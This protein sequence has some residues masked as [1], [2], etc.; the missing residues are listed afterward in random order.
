M[1]GSGGGLVGGGWGHCGVAGGGFGVLIKCGSADTVDPRRHW[2]SSYLMVHVIAA[3]GHD[4]LGPEFFYA[5][6]RRVCKSRAVVFW[7]KW[8][9]FCL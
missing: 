4:G 6:G 7:T 5:F 1:A 2:L 3:H 8:L 9:Q